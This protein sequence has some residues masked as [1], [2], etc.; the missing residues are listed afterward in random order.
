MYLINMFYHTNFQDGGVL[1]CMNAY[2]NSLHACTLSCHLF[3]HLSLVPGLSFPK[4]ILL[5]LTHFFLDCSFL[6][7]KELLLVITSSC[8]VLTSNQLINSTNQVLNSL[9]LLSYT[10]KSTQPIHYNWLS[11]LLSAS[12]F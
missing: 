8:H 5:G 6:P 7:R 1:L 11:A 2:V 3:S 10:T 12:S 9:V 4:N